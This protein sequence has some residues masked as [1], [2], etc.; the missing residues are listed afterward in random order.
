MNSTVLIKD[1][2]IESKGTQKRSNEDKDEDTEEAAGVWR[3]WI[4][5]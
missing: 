5:A 3:V 1:Q 2:R 4:G